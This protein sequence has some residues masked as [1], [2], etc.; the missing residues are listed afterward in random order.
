MKKIS[1]FLG[2]FLAF[3]G[4]I[5]A[6]EVT[7]PV[8]TI[9]QF[10]A[11]A[12]NMEP[13]QILR[14]KVIAAVQQSDRVMVV[15]ATN[16]ALLAKEVERRKSELAMNDAGRVGDVSSLMSNG[17][18]KGSLD[19]LS[20]SESKTQDKKTGKVTVSYSA[21]IDYTLSIVNAENGTV[22][23]QKNFSTSGFGSTPQA[24][25]ESAINIK[26]TPVKQFI[27]NTYS[28]GGKV[29]AADQVDKKKAKT[30]YI[31]LGNNDGMKKGMKLEVF[32]EVEIAGEKSNKLIG[33]I[34]IEEVMSGSRSLCK[35]SKGGEDILA[36]VESG[37]NLP[38]KT[39]E[40]KSN[41]F[42]QMIEN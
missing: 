41:F 22:L 6:Q 20:V 10:T 34:Q 19:L 30:V 31:D 2:F 26:V 23:A 24:A 14:N 35:V 3:T 38:I 13:A 36:A 5:S 25:C 37:T 15:D 32:K 39:K 8:L 11:S 21:K 42:Q 18:M 12:D 16:A 4:I 28:V 33:E 27:V 40:Q 29:I 7:K 1:L 9:E 17:I